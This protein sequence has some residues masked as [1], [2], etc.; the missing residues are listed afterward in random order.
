MGWFMTAGDDFLGLYDQ[1]VNISMGSVLSG[2][3][4]MVVF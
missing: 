3:G 2:Y 1:N 4:V